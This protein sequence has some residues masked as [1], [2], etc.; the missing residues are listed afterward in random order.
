MRSRA[1]CLCTTLCLQQKFP[2]LQRFP[3]GFP[4]QPA[5]CHRRCHALESFGER[6]E[7]E[8]KAEEGRWSREV[9]QA[10]LA[11]IR[12]RESEVLAGSRKQ[13]GRPAPAGSARCSLSPHLRT[14]APRLRVRG[15]DCMG[16]AP[17]ANEQKR[18]VRT[19]ALNHTEPWDEARVGLRSATRLHES[20]GACREGVSACGQAHPAALPPAA[21]ALQRWS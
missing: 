11:C 16:A 4:G 18:P 12:E 3:A 15:G 17:S 19:R 8:S 13:W 14:A 2:A 1:R 10:S 20:T 6:K 5:W 9:G 21:A 7:Q